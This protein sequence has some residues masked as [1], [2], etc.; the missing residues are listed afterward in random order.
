M[1]WR[2]TIVLA[3]A[4]LVLGCL[5]VFV[6]RPLRLERTRAQ[7]PPRV[8]PRFSPEVVSRIEI[9]SPSNSVVLLRTGDEW[10]V[11]TPTPRRAEASQIE[12]L[13]RNVAGLRGRSVLTPAE[14]RE[15]PNAA[16]E[17]G[18]NPPAMNL[19]FSGAGGQYEL[20]IGS[21]SFNGSRIYYQ[22]VGHP[23]IFELNASVIDQLPERPERW[24]E[25]TLIPVDELEFD[26]IHV[27]SGGNAFTLA[28]GSPQE[29]WALVEPRRARADSELVTILLG[30][31]ALIQ[32]DDFI[33]P[34][35]LP[36]FEM[37]GLRPPRLRL[38]LS[39]ASNEVFGLSVGA[40]LT[41]SS[42]VLAQ[43]SGEDEILAIPA[44]TLELLRIS[45]RDLLDSRV[46]RFEPADVTEIVFQGPEE[47]RVTRPHRD[48]GE[49]R[50][51]PADLPADRQLVER[52]L[53]RLARLDILDI[54]KEVVTPLDLP[55]FGL[56]P[57]ASRITVRS[58]PGDTNATLAVL[59]I[60]SWRENQV[61]ARVPGEEP[62]YALNP[63]HLS[64]LPNAAWRLRDRG[65]WQFDPE[66]VSAITVR[67]NDLE[68]TLRHSGTN[69][70][71]TPPG[72]LDDLNPFALEEAVFQFANARALA[73]VA[74]GAEAPKTYGTDTGPQVQIEFRSTPA[75]PP[76]RIALGKASPAGNRYASMAG[77]DGAPVVF[78]M[79]GRIIE[80]LWRQIDLS[81]S[82][83]A[84][85]P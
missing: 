27:A 75:R 50:L 23:G 11:H 1:T 78:E 7:A 19:V 70:W 16:A 64:E 32:I 68:W 66:E 69:E 74:Q 4:A 49:W 35:S 36:P 63:A 60:G 20:L 39:S 37:T 81:G 6:E 18:L 58:K 34:G 62:V 3:L 47:F 76:L 9:R 2:N 22:V 79:P 52:T 5:I 41:N 28:R 8:L 67:H 31:L 14:L 26:R 42:A 71:V 59:E 85:A 10:E 51:H 84:H 77:P 48:S 55:T 65:L 46:I 40:P 57:P 25:R 54:V 29:P 80:N 73:W 61:S 38:S 45:Y 82:D 12:S 17:F 53:A 13:L 21:R 83:T 24:R 15:R 44:E 43:R 56:A 33:P 30:Q 72:W